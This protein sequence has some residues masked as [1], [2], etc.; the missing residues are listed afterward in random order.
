M[1][2]ATRKYSMNRKP[3]DEESELE[4]D[5]MELPAEHSFPAAKKPSKLK[6]QD[7]GFKVEVSRRG[8]EW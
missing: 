3:Q 8:G 4:D 2:A 6:Y 7:K 5:L 1:I